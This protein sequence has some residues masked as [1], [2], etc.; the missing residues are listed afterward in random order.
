MAALGD[1]RPRTSSVQT[2]QL[3]FSMWSPNRCSRAP[4]RSW[5]LT[6]CASPRAARHAAVTRH[7]FHRTFVH[8]RLLHSIL[9]LLTQLYPN[10][11]LIS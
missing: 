4:M 9:M 5:P 8:F 7:A 6:I 11:P 1:L 10:A 2:L 3:H